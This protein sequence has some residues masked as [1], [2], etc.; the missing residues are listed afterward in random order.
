[1]EGNVIV[2]NC[3]AFENR[4]HGLSD[5][6]NPGVLSLKNC[7]AYNNSATCDSETGAVLPNGNTSNNFD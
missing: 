3:M 4:L 5:N 2:E 1:M 6:S 7:T